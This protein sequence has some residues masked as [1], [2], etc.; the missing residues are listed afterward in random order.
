[1]K[2]HALMIRESR[3]QEVN[4]AFTDFLAAT[5]SGDKANSSR[6]CVMCG[7]GG[8]H[9][10]VPNCQCGLRVMS[11]N[12]R[13][14]TKLFAL[15]KSNVLLTEDSVHRNVTEPTKVTMNFSLGVLSMLASKGTL[16]NLEN[17]REIVALAVE[18]FRCTVRG[19]DNAIPMLRKNTGYAVAET[20]KTYWYNEKSKELNLTQQD[21]VKSVFSS[22]FVIVES[23]TGQTLVDQAFPLPKSVEIIYLS[24]KDFRR[25]RRIGATT[26]LR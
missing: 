26:G 14:S 5:Y 11:P 21:A 25:Y 1:M 9:D 17:G 16:E 22:H 19:K 18:N 20:D 15:L 4:F 2:L 24:V 3:T 8:S 6:R 23:A 10:Q 7:P 13:W 12:R